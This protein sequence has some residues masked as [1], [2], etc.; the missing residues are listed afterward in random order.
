VPREAP[1]DLGRVVVE[2]QIIKIHRVTYRLHHEPCVCCGTVSRFVRP[3]L[4]VEASG[5]LVYFEKG[6]LQAGSELRAGAVSVL[7]VPPGAATPILLRPRYHQRCNVSWLRFAA[8]ASL[9]FIGQMT[10][11]GGGGPTH[12]EQAANPPLR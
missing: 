10:G 7:F 8:G 4:A 3:R 11:F 2:S 6:R 12:G 9:R 1:Y 5:H